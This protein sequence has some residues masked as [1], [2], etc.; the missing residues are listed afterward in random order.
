[1][2]TL[3]DSIWVQ[4]SVIFYNAIWLASIFNLTE[5]KAHVNTH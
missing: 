3:A 2:S 4:W 1:M 5:A